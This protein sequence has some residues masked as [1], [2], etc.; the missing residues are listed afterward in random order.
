[1][2]FATIEH[3][4]QEIAAIVDGERLLT[5]QSINDVLGTAWPIGLYELINE[6]KLSSLR[7]WW[8]E[9]SEDEKKDFESHYLASEEAVYRPLYRHPRK[10]WGIGLNFVD[11]ASDLN[12]KV[13]S[14]EPAS[15][16][17]PETT[18]I[19]HNDNIQLPVQSERTTGEAELGVIIGKE[20]KNISES[21]A[22][23][24]IAGYT[25]VIDMTTEDILQRNPRYLTRS[26]SFDTFFSFGPEFITTDEVA[27]VFALEVATIINGECHRKNS[28]SNMTFNPYY[29][30]AF[31]S[32]VMTLQPGD[33][34]STGTPGAGVI[35]DGDVIE[36]EIDGFCKLKNNVVDLKKRKERV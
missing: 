11:H 31:H 19:G 15:F 16:M 1:M 23:G 7:D 8:N 10:I 29:L 35:R 27:D 34:I 9:R 17:K 28:V 32:Q 22:K 14:T 2:R 6:E 36:C 3:G 20:C 4:E 21:N 13:P 33:I 26:K 18:I 30:V 12:E 25:T 5:V 24:V